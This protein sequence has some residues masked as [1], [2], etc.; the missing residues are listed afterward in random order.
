VFGA[1]T[2][3]YVLLLSLLCVLRLPDPLLAAK[4][5]CVVADALTALLWFRLLRAETRAPWAGSLFAVAFALSPLLIQNAVCGMETS[6]ALLWLSVAFWA[7]REDRESLLG[8][9]LGLLMLVRPD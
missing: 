5:L 3:F 8:I 7:D 9:A 1:S 2:P 6:F 4:L